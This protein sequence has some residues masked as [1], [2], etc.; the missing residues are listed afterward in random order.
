MENVPA[1]AT[2]GASDTGAEEPQ[3][4]SQPSREEAGAVA[5]HPLLAGLDRLPVPRQILVI[6]GVALVIG[7]AVAVFIWSRE[8]TYKP[9]I[10]RM[11]DH[12]AQDI[13]DILQREY[14]P[15]APEMPSELR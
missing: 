13:V 10:H 12:N 6:A 1:H 7:L 14:I 9:L 8:P 5:V 3:S 4:Q 2:A 11:Q 15:Q